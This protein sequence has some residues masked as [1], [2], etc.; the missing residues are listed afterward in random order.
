MTGFLVQLLQQHFADPGNL[1]D[2]A[3][4]L[5]LG[6]GGSLPGG[7]TAAPN[8]PVLIE[9]I[10][11][12]DPVSLGKRPGLIV[13]RNSWRTQRLGIGDELKGGLAL[14]GSR[15]FSK[16][17]LGSHSVFVLAGEGT[18]TDRW[19]AETGGIL[20]RYSPLIRDQL[21]L[22]AFDLL[23][24]GPLGKINECAEHYGVPVSVAYAAMENWTLTPFAPLLKNITFNFDGM[25]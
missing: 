10:S 4:R 3:V 12:F 13:K 7:W 22:Y 21:D 6:P 11:R 20:L 23:E 2:A 1:T 9:S 15:A 24:V 25:I 14:D 5:K 8:T 19:A 18:E 17:W 16:M